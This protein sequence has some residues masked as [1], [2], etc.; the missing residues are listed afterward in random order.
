MMQSFSFEIASPGISAL[1]LWFSMKVGNTI[2]ASWTI[3][4]MGLK[5]NKY[6]LEVIHQRKEQR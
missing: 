4:I 2:T 1:V 6:M 5:G 3:I